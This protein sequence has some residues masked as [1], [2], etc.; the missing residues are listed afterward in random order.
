MNKT[1]RQSLRCRS[2]RT[3]G[4]LIFNFYFLI[5]N[6]PASAELVKSVDS[7]R[8]TVSDTDRAVEFFSKVLSFEK[9]SDTEVAGSEYERLYGVFG[10]RMRIV[11][12]KLRNESIELTE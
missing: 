7:V 9:T 5:V 12:M 1:H 10:A 2:L 11:R 4:V 3:S 6:W 8:I